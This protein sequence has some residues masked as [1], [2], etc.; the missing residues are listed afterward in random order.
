[1]ANEKLRQPPPAY[2]A[3]IAWVKENRGYTV[4]TCWIAD[5]KE[6][7]GYQMKKAPNRKGADRVEPCPRSKVDD[8]IREA[9]KKA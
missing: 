7:M 6:E 5:I 3:V 8:D 9:L 1:M 4:K 2:K